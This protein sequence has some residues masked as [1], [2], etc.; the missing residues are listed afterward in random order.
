MTQ[1]YEWRDS[2]YMCVINEFVCVTWLIYKKAFLQK[3]KRLLELERVTKDMT[4]MA[5]SCKTYKVK[6]LSDSATR[7]MTYW[8]MWYTRLN[9][10]CDVTQ[11]VHVTWLNLY[12]W[13][14]FLMRRKKSPRP[15]SCCLLF[16]VLC[17][18]IHM[19]DM[20][21]PPDPFND[22]CFLSESR[23]QTIILL[24][25]L[26]IAQYKCTESRAED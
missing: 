14:D 22:V 24:V 16:E 8:Y 11:F 12:G 26:L 3:V 19:G 6:C 5:E 7:D 18:F 9:Y 17:D 25:T 4:H 10:T 2:I 20:T 13:H 21:H 23:F 1:L 15:L